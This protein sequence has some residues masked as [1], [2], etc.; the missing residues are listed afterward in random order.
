MSN[1]KYQCSECERS[2]DNIIDFADHKLNI[3]GTKMVKYEGKWRKC[4]D[5]IT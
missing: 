2:Y 5:L 4:A 3:H 1:R